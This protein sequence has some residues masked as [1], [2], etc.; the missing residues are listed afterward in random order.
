MKKHLLSTPSSTNQNNRVVCFEDTS[1]YLFHVSKTKHPASVIML[2]VVAS[3]RDKMPLIWFK[4]GYR[5]TAAD[6][7]EILKT[8]VLQEVGQGVLRLPAGWGIR[9]HS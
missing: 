4:T 3:T 5:L 7:L 2:G 6:Y 8:K 1:E 9:P